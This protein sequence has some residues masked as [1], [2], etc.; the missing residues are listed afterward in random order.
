M[1]PLQPLARHLCK[2]KCNLVNLNSSCTTYSLIIV[3]DRPTLPRL[4]IALVFPV[5]I[6][7][8]INPELHHDLEN[9]LGQLLQWL[10]PNHLDGVDLNRAEP[11]P[12]TKVAVRRCLRTQSQQ[13]DFM[14]LWIN[15]IRVDLK[16]RLPQDIDLFG[17]LEI[18][19]QL[20]SF[21]VKQLTHMKLSSLADDAFMRSLCALFNNFLLQPHLI[22]QLEQHIRSSL[23]KGPSLQLK[24]FAAVGMD[25]KLRQIVVKVTVEEICR[26]LASL[27]VGQWSTPVLYDLEKW[28]RLELY[29]SF[30]LGCSSKYAC[31][32]SNDL[33]QIARDELVLLRIKEIYEM[34]QLYP[35]SVTALQELRECLALDSDRFQSLAHHRAKIVDVFINCCDQRLLHLGTNT[36]DVIIM[37]TKVIKSFLTID[38]TGVLLDKVVRPIR[39][40]LSTRSDF[41]QQ[42]VHGMLDLN[43]ETNS[44]VELAQEL[45]K[46]DPPTLAPIDILSD[47]KWNPDPIDALPDFKKGE[48]SD[49]L[50]A[51]VSIY[52]LPS[53]FT[54]ELTSIFGERLLKWNEYSLEDIEHT[55][56]LLKSRFGRNEFNCLDVMI[57]D[58]H[59]S[60]KLN[61]RLS[62]PG[63]E[64]TILS[65]MY[66]PSVCQKLDSEKGFAIPVQDKF[67]KYTHSFE[68]VKPGRTLHLHPSL[69]TV[70]LDLE[71]KGEM[72]KF[73]VTPSQATV[74]EL[75]DEEE[76]GLSL[77]LVT[78][79]T[80]LP[81]YVA[82]QALNFWVDASI[83]SVNNGIY[84]VIE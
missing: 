15:S 30:S 52:D 5:Q 33:I 71:I 13:L 50:Q 4:V 18:V 36:V 35:H 22:H 42:V 61:S 39:K 7:G 76:E 48:V 47:P 70:E 68:E 75:F 28:L 74:I 10:Q 78:L 69:G 60:N 14:K 31:A 16:N 66:W 1:D 3:M 80:Q 45:Q 9:D 65:R 19:W 77:A 38:P 25:T 53:V 56:D 23:F 6:L 8:D 67:E 55:T 64:L 73:E 51:L 32:S 44:L 46:N 37:Y 72:R 43:A 12:R 83:L 82:T 84:K 57:K 79:S 24:T 26:H 59:D 20:Q 41:V 49:V 21:Y 63:M 29:P 11:L 40:Y 17:A 62:H 81:E 2:Q 58:V 34:V 27:C 54:E